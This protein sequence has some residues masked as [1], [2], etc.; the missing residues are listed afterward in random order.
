MHLSLAMMPVCPVYFDWY[1]IYIPF[2]LGL[3]ILL[4]NLTAV[5]LNT[6]L[7]LT[8]QDLIQSLY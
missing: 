6:V 3:V 4:T 7:I 2:P 8:Y 5:P 1:I